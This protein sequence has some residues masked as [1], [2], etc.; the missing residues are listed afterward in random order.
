MKDR[1]RK[2][3]VAV[4]L[5]IAVCCAG[6]LIWYYATA[7]KTK[8]SYDDAKKLVT[9]NV[10]PSKTDSDDGEQTKP[11]IPVDFTA[12]QE[13]NPDIY[14]W[15]KIDGTTVDYPVCQNN[16]DDN[17]YLSHTWERVEAADGAIF[18]QACNSKN[19]TDFNTVIYG[20]QMGEGVDTMFHTLDRYL[21]EGYIEKY[22]NVIIYTPDHVLTYRIFA[23]VIYDDRHLI[24]SFNYVMDDQRQAFLD[25][26]QDS[27]DLRSRYSDIESVG[28]EDRI[29][30][31]STCVTGESNH[32]LLVEAVLTNEE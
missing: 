6:Y 21:E 25:S 2:I 16:E 29:L 22:P 3:I 5:V 11:E 7:A 18:T 15:I 17:Y 30:S 13:K 24:N 28:T 4:L 1:I 23:A 27:R 19:F 31:L 10:K 12:L 26:L 32:R 14:A 20:H 8:Q 9:E